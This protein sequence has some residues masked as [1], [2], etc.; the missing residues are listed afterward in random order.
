MVLSGA[1]FLVPILGSVP[2]LACGHAARRF[3]RADPGLRGSGIALAGLVI[4]YGALA[5][6]IYVVAMVTWVAFHAR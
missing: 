3:C 6:S 1:G 5:Y 4:G 2:A